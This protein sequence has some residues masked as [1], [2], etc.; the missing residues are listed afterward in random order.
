M[1]LIKAEATSTAG[2]AAFSM[3]D[4]ERHAKAILLRA[5]AKAD[6]ILYETQIAADEIRRSAQAE[7]IAVGFEEGIAKGMEEG[8][9]LGHQ[10]ALD[11]N[12]VQMTAIIGALAAAAAELDAHRRDMEAAL[13]RDVVDLS[14]KI[15]ERV[16][17]RQGQLDP[18]VLTGNVTE[19]L[20]L[21][22]GAHDVRIAIHPT[23]RGVLDD[24]MPRLKLE[25]PT[26]QHVELV[27][28][29]ALAPGGCRV[30]TRQGVID[31]DLDAQLNRIASELLPNTLHE[32]ASS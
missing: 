7:G 5:R 22:T 19:A 12:R 25:F 4:I 11:E 14:V 18:A 2:L 26:L 8:G 6:Q 13:I 27:D 32:E 31:A 23:Q 29:A 9:K 1:G 10:Q 30:F 21:V 20:N 16:T 3:A 15:S 24:V 17:K 28:D